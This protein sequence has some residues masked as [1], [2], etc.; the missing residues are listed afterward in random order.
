MSAFGGRGRRWNEGRP[1][2]VVLAV[3]VL[4][5]AGSAI[6]FAKSTE[7]AWVAVRD[8]RVALAAELDHLGVART[9]RL[10]SIDAASLTYWTGRP[11]IVTP[12]DPLDT[13]QAAAK[14]YD[15]RWLV[16]EQT[17]YVPALAPVLDGSSRPSW[18]GPAA[19]TVPAADGGL[20]RLA[21]Y[22]VC[23]ASTDPRCVA[24]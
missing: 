2:V 23:V 10:M 21:L 16:L 19:F 22:P 20:P 18:I 6:T 17:L 14:A 8:Q 11:G 3:L 12:N 15:V 5:M 7:D 24:R 13:I 1:A 9:E 4:V